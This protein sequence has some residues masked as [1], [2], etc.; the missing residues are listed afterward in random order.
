[1]TTVAGILI[2]IGAIFTMLAGIGTYRFSDVYAR[3][4]PAAKGPTLGLLLV[5]TGAALELQSLRA[6]LALGLVVIL[7]FLA[8]PV[9][10]HLLGRAIH[11]RLPLQMEEVDELARDLVQDRDDTRRSDSF[12]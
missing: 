5:A 9:G 12:E 3:M 11:Q 1:M 8:A 4:H 10:A 6:T 7:Q 2:V